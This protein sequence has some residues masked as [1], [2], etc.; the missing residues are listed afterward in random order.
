M[1]NLCVTIRNR[2]DM[3]RAMILSA[4][5]GT[6]K[7]DHVYIIDNGRQ[8]GLLLPELNGIPNWTMVDISLSPEPG[9]FSWSLARSLNWFM[10]LVSEERIIAHDDLTFSPDSIERFV[11]VPGHFLLDTALGILTIRDSCVEAVGFHDE[12][13]SPGFYRYEDC[14][15]QHRMALLD[16]YPVM[17][18][19]GINHTPNGTMR[20][21]SKMELDDYYSRQGLAE[22]NYIR[23]WGGPP[24]RGRNNL[25]V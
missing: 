7:P 22:Q 4:Y 3:I 24:Q 18:D 6:V 16:I 10:A 12:T 19:C 17:V 21:Y 1:V 13:I 5:A 14:D 11:A 20:G 2:Y 9:Q 8:P 25:W 15:Y 23:K